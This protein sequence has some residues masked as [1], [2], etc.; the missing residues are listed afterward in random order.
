MSIHIFEHKLSKDTSKTAGITYR[1]GPKMPIPFITHI[2]IK[3]SLVEMK[4]YHG[5]KMQV[6]P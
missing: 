2:L 6:S 3:Q 5:L 4:T 1:N